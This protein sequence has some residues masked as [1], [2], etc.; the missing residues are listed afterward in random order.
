MPL[1]TNY[2]MDTEGDWR[3]QRQRVQ[4]CTCHSSFFFFCWQL[5]PPPSKTSTYACSRGQWLSSSTILGRVW[6]LPT[7]FADP[8]HLTTSHQ[9]RKWAHHCSFL[10]LV[11]SAPYHAT[12]PPTTIKNKQRLARFW[13]WW[14]PHLTTTS[15][16]PTTTEN[17][18]VCTRF[19]CW[20]A[21][22]LTTTHHHHWKQVHTCLFSVVVCHTTICHHRKRIPMYLFSVVLCYLHHHHLLPPSKMSACTHFRGC[23]I[24]W[25]YKL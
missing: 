9:H 7:S 22:Y 5:A 3:P 2:D 16:S 23:L 14:A 24:I 6:P 19:R 11:G 4:R 25:M 13:C 21:I 17:E 15:P 12:S 8:S 1:P 18:Y 20:S 10:M